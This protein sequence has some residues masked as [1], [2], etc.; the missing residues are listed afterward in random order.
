MATVSHAPHL[1]AVALIESIRNL[2]DDPDLIREV[3]GTG[4][5]DTTRVAAGSPE[6]WRDIC[7]ENKEEIVKSLERVMM[8]TSRLRKAIEE[9]NEVEVLEI[10]EKAAEYRSAL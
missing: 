9:G 1:M 3:S 7:R 6:V 2:P 4:L 5:R 10:L 8:E